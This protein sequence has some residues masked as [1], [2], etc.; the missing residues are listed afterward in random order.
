MGMAITFQDYISGLGIAYEV[1]THPTRYTSSKFAKSE[2]I[3]GA[4]LAKGG[5]GAG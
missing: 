2:H 3:P 5:V 1:L 4:G